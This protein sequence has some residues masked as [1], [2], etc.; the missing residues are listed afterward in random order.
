MNGNKLNKLLRSAKQDFSNKYFVAA[1]ICITIMSTITFFGNPC[2]GKIPIHYIPEM[3]GFYFLGYWAASIKFSWKYVLFI[4]FSTVFLTPLVIGVP[5]N[6]I[7][8]I[9]LPVPVLL[10][11]PLPLGF[12]F[13]KREERLI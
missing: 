7:Y 1:T 4:Y 3:F 11:I 2:V 8:L 9:T 6:F 5:F 13:G 12:L 10:A